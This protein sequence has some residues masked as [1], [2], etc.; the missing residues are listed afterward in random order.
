MI[1]PTVLPLLYA[2]VAGIVITLCLFAT[3]LYR[4]ATSPGAEPHTADERFKFRVVIALVSTF[5][6]VAAVV[7]LAALGWEA[8]ERWRTKREW[9]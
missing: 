1:H 8:I 6:F 4:R 5:W 9:G 7:I 3:L 2:Y